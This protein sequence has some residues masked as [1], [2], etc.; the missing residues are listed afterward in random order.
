MNPVGRSSRALSA[1][2]PV[3]AAP[4]DRRPPSHDEGCDMNR[5]IKYAALPVLG[6]VAL[7]AATLFVGA[8]LGD[9]KMQRKIELKIAPV[10]LRDIKTDNDSI[11]RGLYIFMSRGCTECHGVGGA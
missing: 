1:C 5:W 4:P 9:R 2:R 10:A 8:Q 11:A 3:S 6:L 7:A